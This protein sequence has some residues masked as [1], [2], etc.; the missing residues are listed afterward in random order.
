MEKELRDTLA[1]LHTELRAAK[2]L[3]AEARAL[4]EHLARDI[5]QLLHGAPH[6]P[7]ALEA[8]GRRMR[9]AIDHFEE[10]HPALTAAV[11]RVADALAHL[12][13]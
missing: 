9:A 2:P 10:T 11:N 6:E 8:M 5:E 4:L 1:R 3:D 7:A 13:I 12:G